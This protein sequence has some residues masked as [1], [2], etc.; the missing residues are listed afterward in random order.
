MSDTTQG[1]P[2]IVSPEELRRLFNEQRFYERALAGELQALVEARGRPRDSSG[3][4]SGTVSEEV[5]YWSKGQIVARVHQF[6]LPDGSLSASK[7]P[8][9]KLV[10][11]EG[12]VFMASRTPPPPSRSP[13][14]RR[15]NH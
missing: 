6:V 10:V 11:H 13:A 4:P 9:P 2:V 1:W 12:T 14:G 8:D 7:K 5:C 3:Q 15:R